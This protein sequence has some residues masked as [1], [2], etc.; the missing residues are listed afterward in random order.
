MSVG[1]SRAGPKRV[2][3]SDAFTPGTVSIREDTSTAALVSSKNWRV[4]LDPDLTSSFTMFEAGGRPVGGTFYRAQEFAD[5]AG[6]TVRALH[7]YDRLG[8][9]KP[10]RT[11]AGYRVYRE[12]DLGRLEQIVALKLIGVPLKR[13]RSVLDGSPLELL[14]ALRSQRNALEEKK[15]LLDITICAIR[16]AE[17]GLQRGEHP[18]SAAFRKII[19][20]IEMQNDADWMLKYFHDD[21]KEKV[22][23]RRAGWT[24]E[25]QA[26]AEQDWSDLFR[27][28]ELALDEDPASPRAQALVER[29]EDLIRQFTGGDQQLVHGV[30]ALY[31]DRA[32]WPAEFSTK[33]RPFMD[34]RIWAFFR[35]GVAARAG[36]QRQ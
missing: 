10:G 34:E 21:V 25:L 29:W 20:V 17:A 27:D 11:G 35:S 30:K 22:E 23:A 18:D 6:V 4:P 26:R 8:L 28:I 14:H 1:G 2:F 36:R 15:R 12:T 5:L 3:T 33:I 9:L 31:A 24:P 7:H 19:E 16:D 32:N 13:I